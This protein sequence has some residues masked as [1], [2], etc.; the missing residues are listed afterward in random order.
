VNERGLMRGI[1][2]EHQVDVQR[3]GDGGVD[4]SQEFADV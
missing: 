2:I 1:V 3:R 4:A